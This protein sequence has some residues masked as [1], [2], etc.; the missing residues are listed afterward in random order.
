MS[1]RFIKFTDV[2]NDE[3][4]INLRHIVR[5]WHLASK[6]KTYIDLDGHDRPMEIPDTDGRVSRAIDAAFFN[7]TAGDL[8]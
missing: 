8:T 4:R 3:V 2:D 6:E 1:E 5:W 7:V